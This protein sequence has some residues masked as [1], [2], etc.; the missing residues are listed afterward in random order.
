MKLDDAVALAEEFEARIR[1]DQTRLIATAIR[2]AAPS[3]SGLAP[4]VAAVAAAFIDREF[5]EAAQGPGTVE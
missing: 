1:A 4:A 3:V 5:G 2:V